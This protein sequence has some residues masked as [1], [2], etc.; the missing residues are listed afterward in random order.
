MH[1]QKVSSDASLVG[2]GAVRKDEWLA[3]QTLV[4]AAHQSSGL[5]GYLSTVALLH[6]LPDLKNHHMLVRTDSSGS[7]VY[8]QAWR[9][10][11]PSSFQ[12][13]WELAHPQFKFLRATH[14]LGQANLSAH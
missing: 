7:S 6:F 10:G 1:L 14:M 8:K 12:I 11:L 5:A 9:H 4:S 13:G 2:W 3:T